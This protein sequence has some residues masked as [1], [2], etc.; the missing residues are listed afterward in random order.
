VRVRERFD[1]HKLIEEMMIQANVAAA[2]ALEAKHTPLIY[3]I[4]D[5][6]GEQKIDTLADFLPTVGLK[7]SRGER[8][9]AARFN[10]VLKAS[11]STDHYETVNEVVLRSQSQAVY[12]TDNIGHFGL[13]LAKYAHFTSPIRRYA[14]LTVHRALIRA[15]NL[16][17]G[18]QTDEERSQLDRI[19]E[20][21]SQNERRAMAAERD[22]VDR[23]IASWLQ[24]RVG[25]EFEGRITGVT[26]FGLFVRLHETGAD[27]L[28]PVSRLG[29][30][31]YMHDEAAHALVGQSSGGRY[32]LGM[33]V[34]VRLAEATPVTGGLL[35]DILTPPESGK[36]PKG[37]GRN[38]DK[39]ARRGP[40]HPKARN[41]RRKR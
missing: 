33:P 30:E 9:T 37:A 15:Y 21:T 22:A 10:T 41:A 6:P 32:R 7:W 12:E 17:A 20:E 13:N 8:P 19:A 5:E 16:G 25:G 11:Q 34:T 27:G 2:M 38:R 39:Y 40:K 4:H 24:D 23:F 29:G 31:Y 1:A 26:R 36:P 14:D 35:F 18:G 3:R 28:C